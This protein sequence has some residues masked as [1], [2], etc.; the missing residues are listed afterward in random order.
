M[1][2]P[3]SKDQPEFGRFLNPDTR[4]HD[5]DL[6]LKVILK[7]LSTKKSKIRIATRI[8]KFIKTLVNP[9]K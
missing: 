3:K 6:N 8:G 9:N 5:S 2:E 4:V 7:L 1:H